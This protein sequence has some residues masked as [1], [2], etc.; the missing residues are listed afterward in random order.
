MVEKFAFGVNNKGDREMINEICQFG[1]KK[2]SMILCLLV[3]NPCMYTKDIQYCDIRYHKINRQCPT[4]DSTLIY[5]DRWFQKC[6][7]N[8]ITDTPKN[9]DI[10][11][12]EK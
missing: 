6:K 4:C 5:R 1:V 7:E 11:V 3:N 9:A 2:T 12:V 8:H 10:K